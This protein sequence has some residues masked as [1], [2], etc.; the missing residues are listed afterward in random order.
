MAEGSKGTTNEN[1]IAP[2]RVRTQNS[3]LQSRLLRSA[4]LVSRGLR[5]PNS[6]DHGDRTHAPAL[7]QLL[8][9]ALLLISIVLEIG[10]SVMWRRFCGQV[11]GMDFVPEGP[12]DSSLAVYCL[13][14]VQKRNRPVGNGAIGSDGTFCDLER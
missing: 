1:R 12:V 14:C 4:S 5:Y 11:S 8:E 3:Q 9:F 6:C 10:E 7:A 2:P 13:E